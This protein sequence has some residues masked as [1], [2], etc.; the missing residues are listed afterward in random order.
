MDFPVS[1]GIKRTGLIIDSHSLLGS[2]LG[3]QSTT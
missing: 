2:H 1:G 3:S